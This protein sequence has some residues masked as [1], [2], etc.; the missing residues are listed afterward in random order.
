MG[1]F[2]DLVA[3]HRRELQVHCYR[4]LGSVDDAEDAVQETLLRAWSRLATYAGTSTF[5]AWLYAIATNV[6][7]DTLRRR[8][9]RV[10]PTTSYDP[11]D[12][13]APVHPSVDV[14]WLTPYPDLLLQVES[15][16]DAVVRKEGIELAFLAAIQLLP[17][18]Q[19]AV[20][21]LRDVLAWSAKEAA[22]ALDMTSTAVNSAL[23]RARA[24]LGN[25]APAGRRVSSGDEQGVLK[26]FVA[27]WEEAD[28]EAI[29]DLLAEEARLVMP[30]HP[31]WF[32]GRSDAMA[33]F[34]QE[35]AGIGSHVGSAWRLVPTGANRQPAFGLYRAND[36]G[37]FM[38][39][40]IGVLRIGP[41][42]IEEIDLFMDEYARFDQFGLADAA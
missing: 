29:A 4:M 41:G 3:P 38:P 14:P 34:R 25:G 5:R 26:R 30:P 1:D 23:L 42:G 27:A 16:E 39:F 13:H 31:T 33:F 40:A 28:L 2:A 37:R 6:C 22:A 8:K 18:R 15:A 7:L 17:P 21:I 10:W 36:E 32:D 24:T 11:S 19:R 20:L 35:M 12:P 9:S